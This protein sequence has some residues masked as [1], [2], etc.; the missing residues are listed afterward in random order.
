MLYINVD[1]NRIK[2]NLIMCSKK[3]KLMIIV[4]AGASIPFGNFS[5]AQIE[6]LFKDKSPTILKLQSKETSLYEYCSDE[7]NK[8]R[9]TKKPFGC[10]Q[11]ITEK[12][13]FEQ[14][15]YEM[16]NIY[17]ISQEAHNKA[18]GAFFK[19]KK[20][21]QKINARTHKLN[22][23]D[24]YDFLTESESLI[25]ILANEM[26][27]KS[28]CF[29][30]RP[31]FGKFQAL[32]SRLKDKYD[33]GVL[34]FNYDDIFEEGFSFA[35]NTGFNPNG[36]FDSMKIV[37]G[38]WNFLYYPHGSLH[39]DIDPYDE[40]DDFHYEKDLSKLI[41]SPP[42]NNKTK[43][44]IEGFS[45]LRTPIIVGYGKAYQT[46]RNPFSLYINDFAKKIFEADKILFVGY[47]FRDIYINNLIQLS[48]NYNPNRK[49]VVID[50]IDSNK[51]QDC[52]DA[53]KC[54]DLYYTRLNDVFFINAEDFKKTDIHSV[55]FV[56]SNN[57]NHPR[58][59]S[60]RGFDYFINNPQKL[61]DELK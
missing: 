35:L 25:C 5:C 4:G 51:K 53:A 36:I 55:D 29:N 26:R 50:F 38:D 43:K 23:I 37:K 22:E 57:T 59:V 49:V 47:G 13:N 58:S 40:D 41:K 7:I 17:A 6:T 44:T 20:F 10:T 9:A 52:I 12:T 1:G 8:F 48:M 34:N 30:S 39:F 33:I 18:T 56:Q 60:F 3:E 15:I 42:I 27:K 46:Q 45:I 54:T 61:L 21:P 31:L 28:T 14:V 16:L 32:C 11:P 2:E 19:L 24:S